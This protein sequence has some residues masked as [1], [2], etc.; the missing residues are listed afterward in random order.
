MGITTTIKKPE[1]HVLVD[2]SSDEFKALLLFDVSGYDSMVKQKYD[3]HQEDVYWWSVYGCI[4]RHPNGFAEGMEIGDYLLWG[5][6]KD[7]NP[8]ADTSLQRGRPVM[9]YELLYENVSFPMI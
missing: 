4:A 1:P 5:T 7:I 2:T 9:E 3:L 6:F 8:D